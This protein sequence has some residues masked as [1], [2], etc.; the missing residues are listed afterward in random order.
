MALSS[1]ILVFRKAG[2]ALEFFLVHPGG[3]FFVKKDVGF[4]TIPK[5]LVEEKEDLLVAAKR[6]FLEETGF[7]VSG[8]FID[9]GFIVQKGGKRVHCFAV[10][11]DLDPSQLVSN[12]FDLE[13]PPRSGKLVSFAEVDRG[14]WFS[15]KKAL[16]KIN[17][18]QA[19]LITNLVD[20]NS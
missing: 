18:A 14:D 11:F 3:P 17:S 19:S 1:G 5:G 9:L 13:W 10:E 7:E 2:E 16:I 6:E 15:Y 20:I 4:W 8:D 12:T